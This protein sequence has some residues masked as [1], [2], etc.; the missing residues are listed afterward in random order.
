MKAHP[1]T[2]KALLVNILVTIGPKGLMAT[3]PSLILGCSMVYHGMYD[4]V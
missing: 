3:K 1:N 2:G 4:K